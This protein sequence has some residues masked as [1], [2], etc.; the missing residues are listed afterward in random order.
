MMKRYLRIRFAGIIFSAMAVTFFAEFSLAHAQ[1]IVFGFDGKIGGDGIAAP[2]ELKEK[3]GDANVKIAS[4]AGE[5]I[6][7]LKCDDASFSLGRE[8]KVNPKTYP[9]IV[10][11]WKALKLPPKG[12][13]RKGKTNDQ[14]LQLLVAFEGEK[15]LSYVWDSNAPEGSMSDESVAWPVSLKIKVIAVKSG[16]ADA[17]KWFTMTRNVYED[18][19]KFFKEEPPPVKGIRVQTNCQHTESAGA[20][21]FG[22]IVFSKNPSAVK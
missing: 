13:L 2:W 9:Y 5:K 14:A 4:D 22:K 20:G 15:V 16:A 10:W 11:Q 12:D 7:Q 6:V 19:K 18:Y 1:A 3:S 8:I 17:G 21:H